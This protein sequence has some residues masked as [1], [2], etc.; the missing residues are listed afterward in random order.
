MMMR[1]PSSTAAPSGRELEAEL[2]RTVRDIPDFPKPGIVF[3]DIT[4][5]L[6]EAALFGRTVRAMAEPFASDGITHVAGIE[7]R[8]FILG[9][10]IAL[11]LGA[12]FVPIRKPGKLPAL[13]ERV[14]YALEYGI[15]ALEVHRDA[16]GAGHRVLLVDDVLAT[17]GTAAAACEVIERLGAAVVGCSLLMVLSFLDG[18]RR[19]E[20]RRVTTLLTY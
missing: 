7:S 3:K 14:D 4:P 10:P 13:V 1:V 9:A 15:D 20:G 11:E 5:V 16:L 12:A 8:G 17:G 6:L 2:R 19:L 18:S